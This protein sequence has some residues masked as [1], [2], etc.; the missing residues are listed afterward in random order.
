MFIY[1]ITTVIE[2]PVIPFYYLQKI[3]FKKE[4]K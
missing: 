4:A 2:D 1:F 3:L